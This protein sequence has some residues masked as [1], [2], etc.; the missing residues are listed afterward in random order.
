MSVSSL[1]SLNPSL[2]VFLTYQASEMAGSCAEEHADNTIHFGEVCP[3]HH[4]GGLVVDAHYEAGG[5]PVH[6]LGVWWTVL[7]VVMA[8]FTS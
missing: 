8:A 1:A 5:A 6:K 7:M 2:D 4:G 3:G